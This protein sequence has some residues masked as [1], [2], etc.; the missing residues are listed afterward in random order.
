MAD[1]LDPAVL[2]ERY[3]GVY[4]K[5]VPG[6]RA[7]RAELA[8]TIIETTDESVARNRLTT[9]EIDDVLA[10]SGW[11]LWDVI[12][13]RSTEGESGLIPRQEY[14]TVSF[15]QQWMVFPDFYEE[16]TRAVG[17]ADGVVDLGRLAR[18]EVGNKLN[19]MRSWAVLCT[20]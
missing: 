14:E 7:F 16:I 20:L 18:R 8:T 10:Y 11:N 6:D 17:G 9:Q 13:A 3:R 4:P 1:D 19:H 2:M 12:A 5:G 15:L